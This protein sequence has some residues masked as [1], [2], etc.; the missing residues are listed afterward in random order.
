MENLIIAKINFQMNT[1]AKFEHTLTSHHSKIVNAK[2]SFSDDHVFGLLVWIF[3]NLSGGVCSSLRE[4]DEVIVIGI[5]VGSFVREQ[6]IDI[7]LCFHFLFSN[8]ST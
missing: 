7:L 8:I 3:L 6:V 1:K 5:Y 2:P 4:S